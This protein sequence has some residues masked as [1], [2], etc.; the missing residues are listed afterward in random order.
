MNK[1]TCTQCG[2]EKDLFDFYTEKAGKFGVRGD[3]K[4]CCKKIQK[5][6]QKDY[7]LT[8]T[9]KIKI[10]QWQKSRCGKISQNKANKK[11]RKNKYNTD[12]I[13][14]FA[15]KLVNRTSKFF[16][17]NKSFSTEKLLGCSYE[18]ARKWIE[19]QFT[20]EMNWNNIHIDHI[21]PLSSFTMLEKEQFKACNW[22]N[23]QPLLKNDNLEKTDNWDGT[24][25][26]LT[27]S[28][29]SL[30]PEAKKEIIKLFENNLD[31]TTSNVV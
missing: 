22:R 5:N 23:L 8:N 31:N 12:L 29:Q 15:C 19:V 21:R 7:R 26:N 20:A 14:R 10:K 4:G 3:C 6:Y 1:K 17:G 28:K 11:Y 24:D 27:F 16:K 25:E 30:S 2:I 13:F 18:F 9:G